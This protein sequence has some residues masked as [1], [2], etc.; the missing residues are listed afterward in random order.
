M[1]DL[2]RQALKRVAGL[3]PDA[4]EI[5]P[6]M[7][8]TIVQE[9][10]AALIELSTPV[11]TATKLSREEVLKVA[12]ECECLDEQHYGSLWVERLERFAAAMYAAGA[13]G[14]KERA[15]DV[16]HNL[17]TGGFSTEDEM[18]CVVR[19]LGVANAAILALPIAPTNTEGEP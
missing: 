2:V 14:M 16:C 17:T 9:A 11:V 3:N 15:A 5:G 4:G 10:N 13:S 1:T 12:H 7:L 8:R 19:T 18:E 6:G